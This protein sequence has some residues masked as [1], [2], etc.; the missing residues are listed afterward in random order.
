MSCFSCHNIREERTDMFIDVKWFCLPQTICPNNRIPLEIPHGTLPIRVPE[1]LTV[2]TFSEA[3]WPR[4]R[5][6][7]NLTDEYDEQ[8]TEFNDTFLLV[9]R[10]PVEIRRP[11]APRVE[12]IIPPP[13]I[14]PARRRRG[15]PTNAERAAR[16][17]AEAFNRPVAHPVAPRPVVVAPVVIPSISPE[18]TAEKKA[19]IDAYCK[20]TESN[21][22]SVEKTAKDQIVTLTKQIETLRQSYFAL[23]VNRARFTRLLQAENDLVNMKEE[24]KVNLEKLEKIP[25]IKNIGYAA[26]VLILD[27]GEVEVNGKLIGK[28][29]IL[30]RNN[31]LF[32]KNMTK[33]VEFEGAFYIHPN[34][35]MYAHS[36]ESSDIPRSLEI[37]KYLAH[38]NY[39][40]AVQLVIRI[41]QTALP[42]ASDVF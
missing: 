26:N 33:C 32:V 27:I 20:F 23:E 42:G 6:L 15:R 5:V 3:N 1:A 12:E 14:E 36:Q 41:L 25:E 22:D 31:S 18:R 4:V 19:L 21:K 28:F 13:F 30:I 34:I 24:L 7:L 29:Q 17:A 37:A 16:W 35:K 40:D 8:P 9:R 39:A 10:R 11:V 38:R 2:T